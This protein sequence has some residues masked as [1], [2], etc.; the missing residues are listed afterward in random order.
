[1]TPN[2]YAVFSLQLLSP[3]HNSRPGVLLRKGVVG[4]PNYARR[5]ELDAMALVDHGKT[6]VSMV[7]TRIDQNIQIDNKKHV[8]FMI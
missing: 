7:R 8:V 3:G 4:E 5:G 6:H 2:I 1:L